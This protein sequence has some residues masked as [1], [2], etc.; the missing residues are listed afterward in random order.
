M[1]PVA[2]PSG[3]AITARLRTTSEDE[4]VLD[5]VSAHLGGLRRADLVAVCHPEPLAAGLD[6][7]AQRRTHRERL[8]DRK[9]KLTAR[10]SARWANAI[11]GAN[12]GQCRLSRDAQYR[13]IAGLRAAI[14]AIEKRLVQP[15]GHTVTAAGA[16]RE[17]ESKAAKGLLD[18]GGTVSKA[19]P[20]A[21]SARRTGPGASRSRAPTGAGH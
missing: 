17:A 16:L 18:P 11:I 8:N 3:V 13:H 14:A 15:T 10:S 20:T 19:A 21:A 6:A 4:L 9:G 5:A 1:R 7:T 2:G 12:D